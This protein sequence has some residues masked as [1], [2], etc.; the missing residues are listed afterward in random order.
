[1]LLLHND[2]WQEI[3][4]NLQVPILNLGSG[5]EWKKLAPIFLM[6]ARASGKKKKK[7]C[8]AINY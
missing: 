8:G 1:L 5:N 2:N 7:K 4:G 3:F 6:G